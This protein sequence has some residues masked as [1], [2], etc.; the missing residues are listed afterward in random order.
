M[1]PA[2]PVLPGP[3]LIFTSG[4]SPGIAQE[5]QPSSATQNRVTKSNQDFL[6]AQAVEKHR[7]WSSQKLLCD[8]CRSAINL[9][10]SQYS[11]RQEGTCSPGHY[12]VLPSIG[13]FASFIPCANL[14]PKFGPEDFFSIQKS[15]F[16][17]QERA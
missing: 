16:G 13:V 9:F 1:S 5:A 10:E 15:E 17:W 3:Q 8:F 14:P 6:L 12:L 4:I 7:L 2:A 11:Y